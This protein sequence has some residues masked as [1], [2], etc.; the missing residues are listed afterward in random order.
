MIS[1]AMI[2]AH[3]PDCVVR[4][5]KIDPHVDAA[6]TRVEVCGCDCAARRCLVEDGVQFLVPSSMRVICSLDKLQVIG[7]EPDPTYRR[8]I[9]K[10]FAW[11]IGI[12]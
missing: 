4:V 10:S 2:P 12:G 3:L 9:N 5:D 7:L 1:F 6:F 8:M 11:R